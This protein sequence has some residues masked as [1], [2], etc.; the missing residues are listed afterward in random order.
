MESTEGHKEEEEGCSDN[1]F[2]QKSTKVKKTELQ[3][4]LK[5][6]NPLLFEA[7]S[8]EAVEAWLIDM[9]KYF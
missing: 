4:E 8:E 3:G 7:E 2:N 6:I 9:G 1:V 5:K